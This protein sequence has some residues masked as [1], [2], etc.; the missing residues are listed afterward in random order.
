MYVR[1]HRKE[2]GGKEKGNLGEKRYSGNCVREMR[3][4]REGKTERKQ[5]ARKEQKM[6]AQNTQK[7]ELGVQDNKTES[8]HKGET[9]NKEKIKELMKRPH[10]KVTIK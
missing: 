10:E 7:G 1:E 2:G 4:R 6:Y 5:E 8:T 3:G 9:G